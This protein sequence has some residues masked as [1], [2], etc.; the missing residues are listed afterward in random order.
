MSRFSVHSNAPYVSSTDSHGDDGLGGSR[1]RSSSSHCRR[2][3]DARTF[4]PGSSSLSRSSSFHPAAPDMA[5]IRWRCH[6]NSS[7]PGSG[8]GFFTGSSVVMTNLE[9]LTRELCWPV[10]SRRQQKKPGPA[11]PRP[12]EDVGASRK[13]ILESCSRSCCASQWNSSSSWVLSWVMRTG[14]RAKTPWV[15]NR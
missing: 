11:S 7:R 8:R 4:V 12:R 15:W 3:A 10:P 5:R 13:S 1:A 14:R 2:V 9:P 6:Y